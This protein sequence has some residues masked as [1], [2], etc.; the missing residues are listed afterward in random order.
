MSDSL[1]NQPPKPENPGNVPPLPGTAGPIPEQ[2]SG[3]PGEVVAAGTTPR[4]GLSFDIGGLLGGWAYEPGT[5]S[6]RTIAGADGTP[7]LQM[8]VE[9]GLLQMELTGRPDGKRPYGCESLLEYFGQQLDEHRRTNGS[10]LGF[11]LTRAQCEALRHEAAMYYQRY[12]SLFA[13]EDYA[14]VMRDTTRNLAVLDLCGKFAVDEQDRL[15]LEQYRPYIV[16]MFGRAKAS[17]LLREGKDADAYRTVR[18]AIR[19]IREFFEK[20]QQP[21]G[22]KHSSEVK[23]LKRLAREIRKKL[24]IDPLAKL[25]KELDRAVRAERYEEA[26]RLRDE[27]AR[28]GPSL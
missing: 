5:I 24:P 21:E 8:R 27:I 28:L 23:V 18:Q 16:M 6:V 17:Q 19:R 26:A 14:G 10:D 11:H 1:F 12:L 7:K 4:Q 15:W 3:K 2:G 25:R 22:F 20:F 13:L 9:L